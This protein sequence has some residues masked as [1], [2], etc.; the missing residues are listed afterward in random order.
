MVWTSGSGNFTAVGRVSWNPV[1]RLSV[2]RSRVSSTPPLAAWS[3]SGCSFRLKSRSNRC[4]AERRA[5]EPLSESR[6]ATSCPRRI[7]VISRS[8]RSRER[9]VPCSCPCL[10]SSGSCRYESESIRFS[11]PSSPTRLSTVTQ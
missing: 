9:F 10:S 5:P 8:T 7:S 4:K 1:K 3:S 11:F 2:G 6:S